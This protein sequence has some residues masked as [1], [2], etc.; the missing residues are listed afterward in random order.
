L[1]VGRHWYVSW[2]LLER[3]LVDESPT[4]EDYNNS[5]L[6]LRANDVPTQAAIRAVGRARVSFSRLPPADRLASGASTTSV[7]ARLRAGLL[8]NGDQP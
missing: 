4:V 5:L 2:S 7:C 3:F 8:P 1:H 6:G